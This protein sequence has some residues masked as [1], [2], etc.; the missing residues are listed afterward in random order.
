MNKIDFKSHYIITTFLL[1]IT[2]TDINTI[3]YL[4]IFKSVDNDATAVVE[5][6]RPISNREEWSC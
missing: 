4:L 6:S 3:I 2:L 5:K 1:K